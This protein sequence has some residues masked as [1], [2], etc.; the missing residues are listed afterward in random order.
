MP[1]WLNRMMLEPDPRALDERP[2]NGGNHD[3]MGYFVIGVEISKKPPLLESNPDLSVVPTACLK[4][5]SL[6]TASSWW[7]KSS[8]L[9]TTMGG[10]S[11]DTGGV[12]L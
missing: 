7:A 11:A 1:L 9:W 6:T 4:M 5:E 8:W 12:F 2:E 10:G 3:C